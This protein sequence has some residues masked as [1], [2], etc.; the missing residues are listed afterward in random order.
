MNLLLK[1][2]VNYVAFIYQL[3]Q[4]IKREILPILIE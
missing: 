3:R 4:I 2:L 1:I